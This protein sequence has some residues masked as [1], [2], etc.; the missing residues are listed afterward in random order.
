M[1]M[2]H[3]WYRLDIEV[4]LRNDWERPKIPWPKCAEYWF[5]D[6]PLEEV[7]TMPWLKEYYPL[8][9]VDALVIFYYKNNQVAPKTHIDWRRRWVF[10]FIL[11]PD[12]R[13]LTWYPEVPVDFA[14][15]KDDHHVRDVMKNYSPLGPIEPDKVTDRLCFDDHVNRLHLLRT[16][17]PHHVGQGGERWGF[18]LYS[19][20]NWDTSYAS[21]VERLRSRL[22][23]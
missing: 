16:D 9:E 3:N 12:G 8:L 13:E 17:V 18:S 2:L 4:E 10:Y 11:E 14:D 1:S 23:R 19:F 20:K 7:F 6:T 22:V 15:P 21:T 5:L